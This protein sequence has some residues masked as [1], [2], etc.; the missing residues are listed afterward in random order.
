MKLAPDDIRRLEEFLTRLSADTYPEPPSQIHDDV[1]RQMID[2]LPTWITLLPGAK[3]LDVGCGQGLAMELFAQRGLAPV[4]ITINPLD[5]EACRAKGLEVR[6]MDQSFPQFDDASFDLVWCRHCLEHS[7]MPYF[8][9]SQLGRVLKPGGGLYVEVPAPDT[10]ARHQTNRNHYSVLPK[11][12]WAEL[13][14]RSGIESLQAMD[15]QIRLHAGGD[16]LYWAI[17]GRKT[18]KQ[19][20]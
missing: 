4:G 5:L 11:S 13:I 1:T 19:A 17:F 9:L 18:A 3:V 6:E 14:S 20:E 2:R 10:S 15:V 16:D 7:V 12:G 8:T